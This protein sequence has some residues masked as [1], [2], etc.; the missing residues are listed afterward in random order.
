M[1]ETNRCDLMVVSDGF[2]GY[3]DSGAV[4]TSVLVG[5]GGR[6]G[7]TVRIWLLFLVLVDVAEDSD[8]VDSSRKW[9]SLWSFVTDKKMVVVSSGFNDGDGD[10]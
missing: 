2:K 9:W 1:Q 4:H 8:V 3:C 10:N 5:G 6:R 7:C